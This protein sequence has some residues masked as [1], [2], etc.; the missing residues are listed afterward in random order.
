ML[1]RPEEADPLVIRPTPNLKDLRNSGSAS[2]DLRLGCWFLT[3][4]H[5]RIASLDVFERGASAPP[6]LKIVEEHYVPFGTDFVLHPR[7]FALGITLEWIRLPRDMTG[8]VVGRSSW[9]RRGLVIA[10]ATGVHP[11]FVGC[12]TLELS[13][14]GVIPISL[15]PG[16]GICQIFLDDVRTNSDTADRSRYV[17]S[18]KPRLLHVTLDPA[19]QRLSDVSLER[20]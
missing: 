10:T 8:I 15:K 6:D 18:R 4:R 19:A 1:E 16:V 14:A 2:V 13:N 17:A 20:S 3:F 5:S 12:L 7:S 11:G 9:G